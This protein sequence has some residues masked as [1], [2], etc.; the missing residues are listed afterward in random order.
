M[1]KQRDLGPWLVFIMLCIF[2][3]LFNFVGNFFN[4]TNK[5]INNSNTVLPLEIKTHY[6][7]LSSYGSNA[8]CGTVLNNS[9]NTYHTVSININLYDAGGALIGNAYDSISNL[10]PGKQW[11]FEASYGANATTYDIKVSGY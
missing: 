6:S 2:I 3:C 9:T 5:E 4:E 1:I 8:I 11:K 7:C 10:Y